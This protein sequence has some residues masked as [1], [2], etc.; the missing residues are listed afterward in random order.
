MP[1]SVA[2]SQA[3]TP[4]SQAA[5]AAT[6]AASQTADTNSD[7]GRYIP[8]PYSEI[9]KNDNVVNNS[10]TIIN[11]ADNSQKETE[12]VRTYIPSPQG[13]VPQ[14]PDM[15]AADKAMADADNAE[16]LINETLAQMKM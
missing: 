10:T 4:A 14:G 2:N 13:M 5:A 1:D 11:S 9:G 12:P 3:I 7:E 8:S 15:T 6:A 16:K